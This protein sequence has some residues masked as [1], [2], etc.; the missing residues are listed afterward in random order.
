MLT[1]RDSLSIQIL[2]SKNVRDK[3]ERQKL[4]KT[5][6]N[7]AMAYT[8]ALERVLGCTPR[9]FNILYMET[10]KAWLITPHGVT[11]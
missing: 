9:S 2:K 6:N 1:P 5:I 10:L 11:G 4:A 8:E 7:L 3:Q